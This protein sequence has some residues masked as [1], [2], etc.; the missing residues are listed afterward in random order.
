MVILLGVWWSGSYVRVV[1]LFSLV[2]EDMFL[3]E[4]LFVVGLG[5]CLFRRFGDFCIDG[6]CSW[7]D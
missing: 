6:Y 1:V 5:M 7:G 4:L 2:V 3:E